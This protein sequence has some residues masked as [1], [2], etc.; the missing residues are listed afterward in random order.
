MRDYPNVSES[1]QFDIID[2]QGNVK[3]VNVR[4]RGC[5]SG[6]SIFW[7][8]KGGIGRGKTSWTDI[9]AMLTWLE[10][11][12]AWALNDK[13]SCQSVTAVTLV[14][15]LYLCKLLITWS[16]ALLSV[17]DGPKRNES[18]L[19]HL[20]KLPR[21]LLQDWSKL[22]G[23]MVPAQSPVCVVPTFSKDPPLTFLGVE[24]YCGIA[25][26]A[27]GSLAIKQ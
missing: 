6:L 19:N 14:Q 24:S 16:L 9:Q 7:G 13:L 27:L 20:S 8:Q 12:R 5:K 21:A 4:A 15:I 2:R 11:F 17:W 22:P 3:I 10:G 26:S 1:G 18:P 23:N 25:S